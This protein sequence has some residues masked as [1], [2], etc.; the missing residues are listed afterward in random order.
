VTCK[1]VHTDDPQIIDTTIKYLV[2]CTTG[3]LGICTPLVIPL[4][5]YT[6]AK[7][8]VSKRMS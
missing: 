2:A 6:L 5:P 7:F 3:S 4:L 8:R 1:N